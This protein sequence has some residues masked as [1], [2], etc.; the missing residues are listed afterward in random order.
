MA[1]GLVRWRRVGEG[2]GAGEVVGEW[3]GVVEEA[4]GR[5]EPGR[6]DGGAGSQRPRGEGVGGA[7]PEVEDCLTGGPHLSAGGRE[8]RRGASGAGR[9]GRKRV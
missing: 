4:D 3:G 6:R 2:E 7:R 1:C 8:R 9:V 5:G